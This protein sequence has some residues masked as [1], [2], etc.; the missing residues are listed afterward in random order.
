MSNIIEEILDTPRRDSLPFAFYPQLSISQSSSSDS[1][2]NTSTECATSEYTCELLHLNL[3]YI[4]YAFYF[5]SKHKYVSK[6]SS[7]Q[8][9]V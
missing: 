3:K 4:P 8:I 1:H 6:L 9:Y 7:L 2:S 5:L